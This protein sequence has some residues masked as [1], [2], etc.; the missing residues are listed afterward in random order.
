MTRQESEDELSTAALSTTPI[1]L[2]EGILTGILSYLLVTLLII[3]SF[4]WSPYVIGQT[5]IFLP[6][7]FFLLLSSIFL[8]FPRL[9]SAAADWMSTILLHVAWL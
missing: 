2:T 7:G 3:I 6:G 4:L 8:L 9:M 5:V 1:D